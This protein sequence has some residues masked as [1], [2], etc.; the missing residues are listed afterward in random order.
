MQAL[1]H[2][3]SRFL[4]YKHYG[5]RE[6]LRTRSLLASGSLDQPMVL[7]CRGLSY[8]YLDPNSAFGPDVL[9]LN[10]TDL[11]FRKADSILALRLR[12]GPSWPATSVRAKP[13]VA[14]QALSG[15]VG[16]NREVSII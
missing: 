15:D 11:L 8:A 14:V 3:L 12:S 16:H 2:M 9:H 4:S 10:T 6:Q 13:K 5:K 1:R 7:D